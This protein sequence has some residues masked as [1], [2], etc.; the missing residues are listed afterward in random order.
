MRIVGVLF[1]R[2]AEGPLAHLRFVG[3]QRGAAPGLGYRPRV[4]RR[5]GVQEAP[6]RLAGL[7]E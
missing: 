7:L 3:L 6:F 4:V 5:L 2:D 1:Q